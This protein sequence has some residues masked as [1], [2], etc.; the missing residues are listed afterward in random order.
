MVIHT[1]NIEAKRIVGSVGG[2]I[3]RWTLR[4]EGNVSF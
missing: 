4:E 3:Q 1:E 2:K